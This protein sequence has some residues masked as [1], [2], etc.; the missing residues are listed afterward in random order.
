MNQR[1]EDR[2]L[3]SIRVDASVIGVGWMIAQNLEGTEYP[4]VFG[5]IT[6][7]EVESRYSQ[8]KLELYGVF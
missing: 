8:P 1:K 6:F 5:S 3:V 4:I 7:N 2:G